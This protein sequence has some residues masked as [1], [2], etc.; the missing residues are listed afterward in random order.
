MTAYIETDTA[1]TGDTRNLVFV[2]DDSKAGS[3]LATATENGDDS[4]ILEAT[5][6]MGVMSSY[7]LVNILES[8]LAQSDS[9]QAGVVYALEHLR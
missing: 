6:E 2:K 1:A 3:M 9:W 5:D 8:A 7:E 4:A